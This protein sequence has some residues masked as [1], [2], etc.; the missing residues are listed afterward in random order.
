MK[1]GLIA[2]V[3]NKKNLNQSVMLIILIFVLCVIATIVNPRFVSLR[4]II[5]VFQQ[6]SVLGIIACGIGM[7]LIAGE[8]DISVGYQ[9]SL[10][11]II[12]AMI[13]D[14]VGGLDPAGNMG[15]LVPYA[16]PLAITAPFVVGALL[17][18]INGLVVVKSRV[19]SFIITLGFLSV[20][21]GL[22]LW[23]SGASSYMLFGKFELMGR[24]KVFNLIPV[25]IFYFIGVVILTHVILKY[26]KYGRFLYAIGGNRQAAYVSGINTNRTIIKAYVVV[27][28]L[29]ALAA[30]ILISRVGS[31]LVDTGA[32][33]AL[34]SLAAV[35]VGGVLL[36]GGKGT[37]LN[38]FLGVMLIGLLSNAMVIMNVNPH[39]R[40]TIVGLI[41]IIAVSVSN[42][43]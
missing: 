11:G 8:I 10:M 32:P 28:I 43:L 31:A 19:T 14:K 34:D 16:M 17:G 9:V 4:N 13:I 30:L 18:F 29:N 25:A 41:I 42:R 38:I 33:Y 12:L 20:Y 6:I 37:A 24:G 15:W 39:L 21:H 5:N 40:D 7:L 3:G 27:G 2:I 22:A 36:T 1:N 23:I 26:S 35:I